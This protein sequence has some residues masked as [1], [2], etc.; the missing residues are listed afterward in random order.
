MKYIHLQ[1]CIRSSGHII[2][3]RSLPRHL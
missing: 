1:H 2:A 3:C